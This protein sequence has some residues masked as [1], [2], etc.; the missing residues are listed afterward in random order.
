MKK[1]HLTISLLVMFFTASFSH[2]DTQTI[3]SMKTM[4]QFNVAVMGKIK[5]LTPVKQR[6]LQAKLNAIN[7]KVFE[8]MKSAA[9]LKPTFVETIATL[10][11]E[12]ANTKDL[13]KILKA[14]DVANAD[15][16]VLS[17]KF[18]EAVGKTL[19]LMPKNEQRRIAQKLMSLSQKLIETKRLNFR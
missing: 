7:A 4:S 14:M 12:K 1:L 2:A 11:K 16:K 18:N 19:T 10:K 17:N 8:Y 6:A 5:T 3:I 9:V 15:V 13:E